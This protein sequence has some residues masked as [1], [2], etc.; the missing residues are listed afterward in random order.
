MG[1]G[2]ILALIPSQSELTALENEAIYIFSGLLTNRSIVI[3]KDHSCIPQASRADIVLR[4]KVVSLI[5]QS[6]GTF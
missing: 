4:A 5:E 2:T 6:E 3:I 1:D